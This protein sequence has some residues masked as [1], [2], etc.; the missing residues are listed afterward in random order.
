MHILTC[1]LQYY[2]SHFLSAKIPA[3]GVQAEKIRSLD[4]ALYIN[5]YPVVPAD[6]RKKWEAYSAVHGP[7]WVEESLQLQEQDGAWASV[8]DD[9]NL[10]NEDI[11][12][13]DVIHDYSEWDKEEEE[14][15]SVGLDPDDP[16]PFL[17]M[18]QTSPLIPIDPPY[19]WD[20]LSAPMNITVLNPIETHKVTISE[21]YLIAFPNDTESIEENIDEAAWVSSYLTT[22][23]DPMEPMSDFYVPIL[24]EAADWIRVAQNK[25]EYGESYDH[26]HS[27]RHTT[28]GILSASI[29]WRDL[30]KDILPPGST[31]SLWQFSWTM[32]T[33]TN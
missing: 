22:D 15:G 28:A 29:Y 16:G 3:F 11:L 7:K 21:A 1:S 9:L 26:D 14:W 12:Y 8:F 10:T 19:N 24:A 33:S 20:L 32:M 13:W 4:K 31:G 25:E 27:S 17:P 18:W 2:P 5:I 30:L 23:E 6:E